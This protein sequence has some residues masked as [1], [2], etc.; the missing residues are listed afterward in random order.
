MNNTIQE[1]VGELTADELYVLEMFYLIQKNPHEKFGVSVSMKELL[2]EKSYINRTR[3]IN[4]MLVWPYRERNLYAKKSGVNF[5][6]TII[7]HLLQYGYIEVDKHKT[8]FSKIGYSED[9]EIDIK[10]VDQERV[11][12]YIRRRGLLAVEQEQQRRNAENQAEVNNSNAARLNSIITMAT[13]AGVVVSV[14]AIF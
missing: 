10:N 13:V 1:N 8:D 3:H 5:Y 7:K 11:F 4:K 9:S 14:I 6:R 2:M 12:F